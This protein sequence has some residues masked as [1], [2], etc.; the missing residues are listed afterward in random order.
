MYAVIWT[1][2]VA[3]KKLLLDIGPCPD[4]RKGRCT[5]ERSACQRTIRWSPRI[6]ALIAA[7]QRKQLNG[8]SYAIPNMEW[9]ADLVCSMKLLHSHP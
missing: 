8:G 3:G 1:S 5:L 2:M 7:D 6:E 9:P 4:Q